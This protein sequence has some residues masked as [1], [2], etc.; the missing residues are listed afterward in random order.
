MIFDFG[1]MGTKRELAVTVAEIVSEAKR[2]PILDAFSGMCA[3]GQTLGTDRQ[4]WNNDVQIFAAKVARALFVSPHLPPT[5]TQVAVDLFPA[6]SLNEE[7]LSARFRK[8]LD[9]EQRSLSSNNVTTVDVYLRKYQAAHESP[10]TLSEV[11]ACAIKPAA[12]PLRLFSL[13][14]ADSYFGLRQCVEIDSIVFAINQARNQKSI[15]AGQRDWLLLALGQA[16]L[17][18]SSTTG[19]FAQYLT[20]KPDTLTRYFRQRSRKVWDAWLEIIC[21][22]SPL[23]SRAWRQGNRAYNRETISLLRCLSKEDDRP[24]VIYADP[25]YTDDQYS[26]YYHLLETLFLYDYPNVASKGRYRGGRFQTPFS[27]KSKAVEAFTRL[28]S[29]SAAIGAE[30]IVSYPRDGLLYTC[31]TTPL[32]I[33]RKFNQVTTAH[34]QKHL[35]SSFGA[36]KGEATKSVT[37][38]IYLAR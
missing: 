20:P 19:H 25:P 23:G 22:L 3:V 30:L 8:R 29:A 15:S 32:K 38:V 10:G 24:A 6:F 13:L 4:I 34:T 17:R 5:M 9:E 2:G 26:R 27:L 18:C 1:Y 14:Y 35:H 31:D 37:E 36:S 16:M 12:F 21:D 7:A 33:L 11:A 28:V